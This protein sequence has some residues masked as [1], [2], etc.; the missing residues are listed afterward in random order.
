MESLSAQTDGL[1]SGDCVSDINF[2]K[3]NKILKINNMKLPQDPNMLVSVINM[4]LRDGNFDSLEDLC[5]SL[6]IDGEELR[7]KLS[8]AGYEY[9]PDAN[10][11]R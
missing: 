6:D 4:K 5:R 7:K 1:I 10:Q 3:V 8:E 2:H 9:L 11:F